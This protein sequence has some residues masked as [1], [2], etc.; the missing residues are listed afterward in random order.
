MFTEALRTLVEQ[1]P[2]GIGAVLMGYDGIAVEHYALPVDDV[3]LGLVAVEY[4]NV[5]KEIKKA[6]DI[7]QT[8][9]L[10]EVAIL[11]GGYQVLI[12][13]L[14]PD[15]FLGLTLKRDGNAGKGRFLL[16]REAPGLRALLS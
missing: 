12:R 15:Y 8:G 11:T 9:E 5:L 13:T 2:G 4:A 10:D 14:T 3:D 16:M 7:L 1:T 6:T